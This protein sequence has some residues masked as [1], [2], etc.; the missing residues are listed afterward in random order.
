MDHG[1]GFRSTGT[2]LTTSLTTSTGIS[3][4]LLDDSLDFLNLDDLVSPGETKDQTADA[5]AQQATPGGPA[6]GGLELD[7]VVAEGQQRPQGGDGEGDYPTPLSLTR[8]SASERLRQPRL[9]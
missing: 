6:D 5:F 7:A 8:A 2:A 9:F 1:H 3:T 4:C